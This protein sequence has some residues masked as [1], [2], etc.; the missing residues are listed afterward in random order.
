M[1]KLT[2]GSPAWFRRC[3]RQANDDL[4]AQDCIAQADRMIDLMLRDWDTLDSD[5]KAALHS[6]AVIHYARP[7]SYKPDY[8]GKALVIIWRWS[9]LANPN[10]LSMDGSTMRTFMMVAIEQN[11]VL[12]FK[13]KEM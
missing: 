4:R 1:P 7:F 6:G 13:S 11:L 2:E 12:E 9:V 3:R 5:L 8:G 10:S